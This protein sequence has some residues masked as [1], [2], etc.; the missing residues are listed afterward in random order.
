MV[1]VYT[2]ALPYISVVYNT[3]TCGCN[4]GYYGAD[5]VSCTECAVNTYNSVIGSTIC[6]ACPANAYSASGSTLST[7]CQCDIGHYGANGSPCT[8]CAVNTYKSVIGSGSCS[9]CPANA[10]YPSGSTVRTACLCNAGYETSWD[11]NSEIITCTAYGSGKYKA[12]SGSMRPPS[13]QIPPH[14]H[15]L[16]ARA[17]PLLTLSSARPFSNGIFRYNGAPASPYIPLH[18]LL[19][20]TQVSR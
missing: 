11:N 4:T 8:E 13:L 2:G 12:A 15:I 3:M 6:S 17:C 7:S 19:V 10:Y 14:T 1:G 9:A 16:L 5:G 20:H 18:I